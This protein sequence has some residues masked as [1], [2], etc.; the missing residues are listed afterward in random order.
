[1]TII[2]QSVIDRCRNQLID[3]GSAYRWSDVELLDWI[4]DGQRTIVAA[5]PQAAYKI[6]TVALSAGTRQTLPADGYKLLDIPRNLVG[7]VPGTPCSSVDRAILD[8]QYLTWH[9]GP[10]VPG[11]LHWTYDPNDPLTF[12][13]FPANNGAG[14]VEVV[15]SFMPTEVSLGTDVLTVRDI[16]QTPLMDYVLY[17]AYG[18]DSDFGAGSA[19]AQNY[20]GAFTAFIQAQAG[21]TK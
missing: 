6:V 14:G 9:S 5:V 3:T 7:G 12:F 18:K 8:R 11:V 4:S 21:G 15:Y 2:A 1:M 13:V 19:L 17:R 16:Y 20:L 10:Q